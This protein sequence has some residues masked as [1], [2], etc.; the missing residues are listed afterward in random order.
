VTDAVDDEWFIVWLLQQIS[1]KWNEAV[2]GIEDDDGEFLLIE[3]ADVLPN[4]VT[5]QNA[6]NRVSSL[7]SPLANLF[8]SFADKVHQQLWIHQGHLHLIPLEHKSEVPFAGQGDSTMNPS[9]DPDED[10]FIDR[11]TAVALVRDPSVETRAPKEVE[12]TVW[13]R[14]N[15][16]VKLSYTFPLITDSLFFLMMHSYPKKAEE[17]HHRTLTYLPS[18]IALAISDSPRLITEAVGAFYERDPS[19][20]KVSSFCVASPAY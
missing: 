8:L 9:F 1:I 17:H 16:S 4:W 6:A 13:A 12:E 15:G 10:G 20:L 14:I 18:E 2:I 3:A 19:M 11:N 7:F 5:P